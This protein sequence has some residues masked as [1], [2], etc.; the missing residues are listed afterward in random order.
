[1]NI[2]VKNIV[3]Y[4]NSHYSLDEIHQSI[5]ISK[6]LVKLSNE[7]FIQSEDKIH[8]YLDDISGQNAVD[9]AFE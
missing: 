5:D 2:C 6:G 4:L 9:M 1:M 8:M 7:Q 3:K